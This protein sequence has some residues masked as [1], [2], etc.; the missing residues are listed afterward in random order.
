MTEIFSRVRLN[1]RQVVA[2]FVFVIVT[3]V[4]QMAIPS[5]LGAMIGKCAGLSNSQFG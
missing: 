4:A 3:A 1:V 5:F 2:V